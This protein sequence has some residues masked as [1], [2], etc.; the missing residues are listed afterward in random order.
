MEQARR[1][2]SETEAGLGTGPRTSRSLC[3]EGAAE[4]GCSPG[5]LRLLLLG[6]HGAGKSATGNTILGKKVFLSKFSGKMVTEKCQR[7][8]GTVRGEE[9]VVIDTPNL[10]SSTACAKDKQRNIEHCLKLSAPSLHVLLLVIP[11]GYCNVEDKETIEG[12]LK[13]F[14]AEARRYIIIV[15]T[16]KDDLGDDSMKDYLL[17]D[18]LL[19]GLVE[20]CGRRYCAFNNKAGEAERDSQ[21]AELLRMVKLLVDENGEPYPVNFNNEGNG[22]QD[23]VK[24]ATSQKGDNLH[25]EQLPATGSEPNPGMSEFKVLLLGKRGAG[26]STAGN[27]LLGKRVFETK[28]SD[29]SVTQKFKSESRTW[30]GR[31]ILI[32][33]GPDLLSDLKDFKSD[34]R[35]HAPRGPHA[36]LLVTPLGSFTEYAEMLSTIQESF[37]DE[38]TKYMIV[39][40]TRKEDLEDQNVD[41]FLTSNG[42]LCELVKKCENRYSISNYRATEKEEQCQVDE[43]LQK[44]VKMVQQNGDKSCNFKKEEALHIVLVGRSG[45]GKSATGNSILGRSIFLSQLRAQ[46]VTTKCQADTR[47]WAEQDVVVVDTPDLCLLSSQEREELQRN[48]FRYEMNTVLVLVLQLGRFTAQNK[49]VVGT[50][51]TIFGKDVMEYMIV[52]FTRKEE[53]GGEDIRDYC[54]NTDNTF[55]KE[56][57]KKCGW[58]VCAFNN[59]ET[60]Q[61]MEDQVTD[62]LKMANELTRKRKKRRFFCDENVSKIM[63]DAQERQYSGNKFLKQV[64]GF[65]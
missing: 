8:S 65:F 58:R 19:G 60:G 43:L 48:V 17:H 28:F 11:I 12:I 27:S 34:L 52:L 1:G 21:V 46:P 33:D 56:T 38:L 61:A 44:I 35:K 3:Q 55:L 49:A 59:K 26:K 36:F 47:T 5:P 63:K 54:K 50:L 13:V 64:K 62:L 4:Q 18:T 32:I 57:I 9:V 24:E 20:N 37:E 25:G 14:G 10:F 42:V 23:C 16:R 2:G 51:R 7:E 31:K 6:K 15:V 29:H 53:L 41:T 39:L 40:L 22:F 45:T 30:R